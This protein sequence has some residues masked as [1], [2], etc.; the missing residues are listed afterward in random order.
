[1]SLLFLRLAFSIGF[2]KGSLHRGVATRQTLDGQTLCLVVRQSQII[3]RREQRILGL[4]QV[5][6]GLIDLFDRRLELSACNVVIA[7]K[8]GLELLHL[9]DVPQPTPACRKASSR[10]HCA[11]A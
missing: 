8:A 2:L 5:R 7:R 6:D 1:M 3:L 9:A 10:R 4:L 11:A